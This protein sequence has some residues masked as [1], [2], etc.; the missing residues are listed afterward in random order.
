MVDMSPMAPPPEAYNKKVKRTREG[1]ASGWTNGQ[2]LQQQRAR[3][4]LRI[5]GQRLE[6]V[7]HSTA[8]AG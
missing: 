6:V 5:Y 2:M 8:E 7:V 1:V 4:G 3:R